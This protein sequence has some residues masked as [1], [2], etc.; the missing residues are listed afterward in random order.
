MVSDILQKKSCFC[1]CVTWL[2]AL[3]SLFIAFNIWIMAVWY[4]HCVPHTYEIRPEAKFLIGGK[5]ESFAT[6]S[7][8]YE[9]VEADMDIDSFN[10]FTKLEKKQF[11]SMKIGDLECFHHTELEKLQFEPIG[12][13]GIYVP[14]FKF[15]SIHPSQK[16]SF[17][18]YIEDDEWHQRYRG[19]W[20]KH[21]V[22]TGFYFHE[23]T[24]CYDLG[25]RDLFIV[26]DA[27]NCRIFVFYG[28]PPGWELVPSAINDIV[29]E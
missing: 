5:N 18:N 7:E 3:V 4:A 27:E 26:Y 9:F 28:L 13:E 21:H 17:D 22:A 29:P 10:R 25:R 24:M 23:T 6:L 19:D 12:D 2:I 14:C 16:N 15:K 8:I 11:K 20:Y 1:S